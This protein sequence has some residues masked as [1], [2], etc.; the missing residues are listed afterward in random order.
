MNTICEKY[1][2]QQTF[3]SRAVCCKKNRQH[4]VSQRVAGV[5]VEK[6]YLKRTLLKS[7]LIYLE[8]AHVFGGIL[9][10]LLKV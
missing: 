4:T 10:E 3:E 2:F 6:H 8:D 7:R 1:V 5:N 9:G